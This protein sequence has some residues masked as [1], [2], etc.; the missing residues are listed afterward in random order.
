MRDIR[1]LRVRRD[2]AI[3]PV[4]NHPL[5]FKGILIE[6]MKA[7]GQQ[8]HEYAM[9]PFRDILIPKV[10]MIVSV[11]GLDRSRYKTPLYHSKVYLESLCRVNPSNALTLAY[12]LG[13]GST[14]SCLT[15]LSFELSGS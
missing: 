6:S 5:I 15:R 8:H 14:L 11:V 3:V 12:L 9:E 2:T 7:S 10:Q 4:S 13:Q 1:L